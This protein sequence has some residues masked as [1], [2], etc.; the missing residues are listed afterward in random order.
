M[1]V[2][3]GHKCLP[4]C[5]S[6]SRVFVCAVSSD[7]GRLFL[8]PEIGINSPGIKIRALSVYGCVHMSEYGCA[9]ACFIIFISLCATVIGFA[10]LAAA[11]CNLWWTREQVDCRKRLFRS[12]YDVRRDNLKV[13]SFSSVWYHLETCT[14]GQHVCMRAGYNTDHPIWSGF[15]QSGSAHPQIILH[16]NRL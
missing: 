6:C 11:G 13:T 14:L 4:D 2:I 9:C 10:A 8:L 16:A 15:F 5:L 1:A 12:L 7:C 3:N